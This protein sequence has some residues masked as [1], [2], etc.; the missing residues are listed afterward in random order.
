M[1]TTYLFY[2][3]ESGQREYGSGTSR[4]FALCAVGIPVESWQLLNTNIYNLKQ[5]Y[6]GTPTVEIKS[7]WLRQ[8]AS[9]R[10][11]YLEPYH[12]AEESLRECVNRLYEV[13]DNPAVALFASVVDK[14][15][16]SEKYS[17]PQ[18]PSSLAYRH[19]FERFQHFLETQGDNSYGVVIFDKIH[20][21]TFREKGYENLLARQHL[22]Y[23]QQGTDFVEIN[24][25]VEGL[26]FI[27][28]ADNNFVQ[29]VDLCAYDVFRQFKEHGAQWDEPTGEQWPL[30][31]YF[32]RILHKFYRG[33]GG[34]LAG[35]GIKKYPDFNKLGVPRVN[36]AL[37]RDEL[38]G[39][40][41]WRSEAKH[42]REFEIPYEC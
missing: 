1:S 3:D 20:D 35:Y 7:S 14:I 21:A 18:N 19:I 25:I 28:S 15:Q 8:P 40:S 26:L 30:Y 32:R 23:L 12:I 27:S 33:P 10:K 13:L 42:L 29:L 34:M 16:M 11:R 6:F 36:W 39:W 24:N 17:V 2:V 31:G 37:R 38:L 4:Y 9:A 22:R 41:V 5:S